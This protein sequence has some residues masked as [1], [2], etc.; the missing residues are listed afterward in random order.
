MRGMRA[1]RA[2]ARWR[3]EHGVRRRRAGAVRQRAGR[4]RR[5]ARSSCN[6][7]SCSERYGAALPSF[8]PVH[9]PY[10]LTLITPA[11]DKRITSTFGGL[12]VNDATPVLEMHPVDAAGRNLLDGQLGAECGMTWARCSCRCGSP[13]RCGPGWCARKRAPG[14]AP[15][16]TGRRSRRWRRS[17]RPISP[18][19]PASTTR[20][21]RWRRTARPQRPRAASVPRARR[22]A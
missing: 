2:A 14:C 19:A 3:A 10:P 4:A 11:S 9:S 21:S 12:A 20:A 6:P 1:E 18:R 17:T 5:A 15:V 7:R 22:R 16:P 13:T 8:R